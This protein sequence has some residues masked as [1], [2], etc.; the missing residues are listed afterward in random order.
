MAFVHRLMDTYDTFAR[1]QIAIYPF[2]AEGC[3]GASA[4]RL[5]ASKRSPARP[6]APPSTTPTTTR[7]A[8]A[9]VVDDTSHFY[10]LSYI[11]PR[12]IDDGHY[13]AIKITVDRPGLHLV[14]RNGYNDEQPSPPDAVLQAHLN[15]GPCAWARFLPPSSSSI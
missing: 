8:V 11:P 14:Y 10:T 9:K 7:V 15:Q 13:H 2:N 3:W 12:V 5:S 1:E 4:S 6:A